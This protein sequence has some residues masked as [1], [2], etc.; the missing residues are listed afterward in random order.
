MISIS[1][2]VS[3]AEAPTSVTVKSF[4]EFSSIVNWLVSELKDRTGAGSLSRIVAVAEA[5]RPAPPLLSSYT[6]RENV[7]VSSYTSSSI[8][9]IA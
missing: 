9:A 2:L 4:D 8:T 3:K 5:N 1:K 6:S 7:S